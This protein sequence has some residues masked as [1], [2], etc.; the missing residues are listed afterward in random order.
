MGSRSPCLVAGW[1]AGGRA[2]CP[3]D[4]RYGS[5]HIFSTHF[6]VHR[7]SFKIRTE[8]SIRGRKIVIWLEKERSFRFCKVHEIWKPLSLV[9]VYGK[10]AC[11]GSFSLSLS[12][13]LEFLLPSW[14]YHRERFCLTK[15]KAKEGWG[16][17]GGAWACPMR[18]YLAKSGVYG[19]FSSTKM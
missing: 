3:A 5:F 4:T 2:G 8:P 1:L 14:E 6:S 16:K 11:Y 17:G 18:T 15:G 19:P 10:E 12:L 7:M 9:R 13:V